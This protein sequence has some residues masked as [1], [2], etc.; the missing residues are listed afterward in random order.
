MNNDLSLQVV[1][2]LSGVCGGLPNVVREHEVLGLLRAACSP[3]PWHQHT[4][5]TLLQ[6]AKNYFILVNCNVYYYYTN[7]LVNDP[8]VVD[9]SPIN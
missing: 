9:I 6:V 3:A 8:Q 7:L 2:R 1:G 5:L 4:I